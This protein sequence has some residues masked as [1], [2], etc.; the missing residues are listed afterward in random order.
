MDEQEPKVDEKISVFAHRLKSPIAALKGY[1]EILDSGEIGTLNEKQKEF[2]QDARENLKR[3]NEMVNSILDVTK[4][5]EA[6]YE[7]KRRPVDLV[8]LTREVIKDFFLWAKAS[9]CEIRFRHARDKMMALA[10]PG[11]IRQV[12]ENFI[13]NAIKYRSGKKG[14]AEISLEQKKGKVLFQVRD[15]GIGI[16]KRDFRRV[17]TKFYRSESAMEADPEGA[18]LG[19]YLSKAII[20]LSGGKIW[21]EKNKGSGMTFSFSVPAAKE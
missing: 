14:K 18:G 7:L 11:K 6:R 19:L 8:S 21:F 17:F 1:L 5:E 13:S 2:L 12:I 4:I 10:D 15:E 16:P 20:E 3:M 9:N